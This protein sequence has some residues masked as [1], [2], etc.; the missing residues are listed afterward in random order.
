MARNRKLR[1]DTKV[2]KQSSKV[3]LSRFGIPPELHAEFKAAM[4][5]AARAGVAGYPGILKT[6][7]DQL[8]SHDPLGIVASFA[9]YG[10]RS[11]VS[12][13]GIE[14]P[15]GV[16]VLQHHAELLLAIMLRRQCR[17]SVS[18]QR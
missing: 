10:L 14:Q 17:V 15:K 6:V 1:K 18:S 5:E 13:S 9:A 11:Y 2:K 3:E 12:A 7:K 16:H 8:I 4:L